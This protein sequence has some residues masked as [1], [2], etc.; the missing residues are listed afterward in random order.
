MNELQYPLGL[1]LEPQGP[2]PTRLQTFESKLGLMSEADCVKIVSSPDYKPAE[3]QFPDWSLWSIRQTVN[4]CNGWACA[5]A[6]SLARV[7]RGLPPVALSGTFVYAHISGGRDQGSI[8]KDGRELITTKG[9]C[10]IEMLPK[11]THDIRRITPEMVQAAKDFIAFECYATRTWA[12]VITALA[13]GFPIVAAV[14]VGRSFGQDV[15]GGVSGADRGSGN[16]AIVLR[17]LV[18]K[19]GQLYPV[20]KN[21]WS[22]SWFNNGECLTTWK[23]YEGTTEFHEFF[24]VRSTIDGHNQSNP[25][26]R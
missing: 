3:E 17:R 20:L 16:H 23:H 7:R 13:A 6:L 21:S 10:P 12:E 8:L 11:D 4:S 25:Q 2:A 19:G 9:A 24:A 1:N 18:A 26:V 15:G 5:T 22:K 14:H